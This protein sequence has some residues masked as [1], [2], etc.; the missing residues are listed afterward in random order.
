MHA[1]SKVPDR[2][3][4]FATADG[5]DGYFTTAQAEEAGY[6]RSSHSYHVKAG[7]W[8]RVSRGIYRLNRFPETDTAHLVPWWLWARGRDEVPQGVYSH[9]T[10]LAL[11][12]LADA[13]PAKLHMTVPPGF[14][15]NAP[16]PPA[17][18]LHKAKLHPGEIQSGRGYTV[19][20]ALRSILDCASTGTPDRDQ[21]EQALAVGISKGSITRL[22][23]RDALKLPDL[24]SWL[25]ARMR[26]VLP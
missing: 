4:L 3:Q 5:Q 1:D 19:T 7:N 16:T 13:N 9:E 6:G 11:H 15:R 20:R 25:S 23:V 12:D 10:A 26:E 24:P 17:L 21:L 8:L 14:R 22:E 2:N 18:V